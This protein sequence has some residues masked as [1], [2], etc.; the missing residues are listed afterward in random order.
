M[1][2]SPCQTGIHVAAAVKDKFLSK[3]FVGVDLSVDKS[4]ESGFHRGQAAEGFTYRRNVVR[5]CCLGDH[6]GHTQ[7]K[8]HFGVESAVRLMIRQHMGSALDEHIPGQRRIVVND[9]I[10]PGYMYI[11]EYKHAVRLVVTET[12]WCL[13]LVFHV[14]GNG[15]SCP[16]RHAWQIKGNDAGDGFCSLIGCKWKD[17]ADDHFVCNCGAGRK[18]LHTIDRYTSIVFLGYPESWRINTLGLIVLGIT[19]G[20]W[21]DDRIG[22]KDIIC[23][24]MLPEH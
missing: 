11:L 7:N 1:F 13:K 8:P 3:L 14:L 12:Q 17:V 15:L 10:F 5:T 24:K 18:K 19:R 16:Q 20:R 6:T 23:S 4:A 2:C 9:D 22:Q 21:G